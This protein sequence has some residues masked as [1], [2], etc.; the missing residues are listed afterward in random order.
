MPKIA[1]AH[2]DGA[3]DLNGFP[4]NVRAFGA[5]PDG[6]TD[7]YYAFVDAQN[8]TFEDPSF[9]GV[10][11]LIVPPGTYRIA[12][13][14]TLTVPMTFMAGASLSVDSGITLTLTGALDFGPMVASDVFVG[15]GTTSYSASQVSTILAPYDVRRYGAVGDGSTDDAA[16]MQDTINAAPDGAEI[17]LPAGY[18]FLFSSVSPTL[19]NR[20]D[21][22][23]LA[24][25]ATINLSGS[26]RY[27]LKLADGSTNTRIRWHGGHIVGSN[28]ASDAQQG[29]G[30][31]VSPSSG[32]VTNDLLV[33]DVT[34]E[35]VC[36]GV[37]V[38]VSTLGDAS[39]ITYRR[40]TAQTI[41]GTASGTGYGLV[42]SGVWGGTF[43]DCEADSCG[44]HG[45]YIS[46]CEGVNLSDLR[47]NANTGPFTLVI[48]RSRDVQ[49]SN[50]TIKGCTAGSPISIE[51]HDSDTTADTGRIQLRNVDCIDTAVG[52]PDVAIGSTSPSTSSELYGVSVEG[53]G[54]RRL[55]TDTADGTASVV[56]YS[57]KRVK[58]SD[59]HWQHAGAISVT[60]DVVYLPASGGA[61]YTDDVTVAG[62]R[63]HAPNLTT[64]GYVS[65][66]EVASA[67]ASGT[68]GLTFRDNHLSVAGGS[69]GA[70]MAYDGGLT[71]PNV[72]EEGTRLNGALTQ[73]FYGKI[74]IA[75]AVL[76][77][78]A[79]HTVDDVITALQNLGLVKQS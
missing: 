20:T 35:K 32:T 27:A 58:V 66:I 16:A 34:V 70:M 79:S 51:P 78:G 18:S 77:T 74:P 44:R 72:S 21:L 7:S 73:G 26:G 2:A 75:Q 33:S 61:S 63:A 41:V 40:C 67:L 6:T 68:Q 76:A 3:A 14:L 47:G 49:G 52:Y 36:R 60:K 25:G 56:I 42:M 13:D 59:I 28:T 1:T 71:N 9:T 64:G 11:G 4:L 30:T 46:V 48:A 53:L 15:S 45:F 23:F 38:D 17:V 57:G 54:I 12:H 39:R 31:S 29:I 8:A 50:V 55:T 5:D 10:L 43:E 37:Y 62:I 19:T 65:G 22:T 24:Y 69:G